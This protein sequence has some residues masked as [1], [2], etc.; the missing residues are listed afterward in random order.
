MYSDGVTGENYLRGV[1]EADSDGRLR[2][3]SIFPGA[4]SGRW[5]HIHFEVYASV[6]DA[7]GG[8]SPIVTS[9]LAL[10]EDDCDLVYA[11]S[12]YEDSVANLAGTSL[13]TD[14]IFSDGSSTQLASMSGS[15]GSG[16][17]AA[18]SV[19]V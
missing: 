17:T 5:P 11:T 14:G 3:A 7:T 10:P 6:A 8:G 12:G 13:E 9:Q 2:F 4:Y 1:Q 15:V 18:L 19:P 16:L